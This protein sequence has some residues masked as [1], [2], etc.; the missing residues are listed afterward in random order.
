MNNQ[1]ILDKVTKAI[2]LLIEYADDKSY[3]ELEV[4]H[5]YVSNGIGSSTYTTTHLDADDAKKA[6]A[7]LEAIKEG[8]Q[9]KNRI[10]N[11]TKDL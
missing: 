9:R 2:D 5:D 3:D 1:E 6:I 4:T 11:I 7:E 8:M 10:V